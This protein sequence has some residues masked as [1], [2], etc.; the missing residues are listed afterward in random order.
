MPE[1]W[2]PD[3]DRYPYDLDD[4]EIEHTERYEYLLVYDGTKKASFEPIK[5]A[6]IVSVASNATKA[7]NAKH[8]ATNA[9][10]NKFI[11]FY[12]EKGAQHSS[13]AAAARHFFDSL[14][15]KE[16][17]QFNSRDTATR[18]FLGALRK[19]TKKNKSA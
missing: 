7:A 19:H 5:Q 1:F 9:I 13:K 4:N 11:T 16:Q 15:E 6:I 18:T 17:L 12:Q 2:F 14:V 3:N 10:N 8:A